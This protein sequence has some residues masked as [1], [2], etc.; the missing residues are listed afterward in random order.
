VPVEPE[1][2]IRL[3]LHRQV[4]PIV[5]F[6]TLV[7]LKV[8]AGSP[9]DLLDIAML[10]HLRPGGRQ[11]VLQLAAHDPAIKERL[12]SFLDDP[13]LQRDARERALE[14]KLISELQ[15]PKPS[16]ARRR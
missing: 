5:N 12:L 11:R 15:R 14:E 9:K 3:E 2:A 13:R 10:G 16:R 6:E 7:R 4:L 1:R 8:K